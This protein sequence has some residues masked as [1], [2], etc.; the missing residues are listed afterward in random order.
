MRNGP[1]QTIRTLTR[2]RN[3][4]VLGFADGNRFAPQEAGYD[5]LWQCAALRGGFFSGFLAVDF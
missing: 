3:L 4:V 2:I 5:G 1:D